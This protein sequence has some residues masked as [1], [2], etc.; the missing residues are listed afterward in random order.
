M[1]CLANVLGHQSDIGQH[2]GSAKVA[3]RL[4]RNTTTQGRPMSS[5]Q[6]RHFALLWLCIL[7]PFGAIAQVAPF[8]YIA[9]D[10]D[11]TSAWIAG[12]YVLSAT[13]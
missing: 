12:P 13:A 10:G 5:L 7:G 11:S 2:V 3:E 1:A 8:A 4:N 6:L 9:N